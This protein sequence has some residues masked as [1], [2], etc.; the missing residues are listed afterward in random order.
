M[1]DKFTTLVPRN[2]FFHADE[3]AL[4]AVVEWM[5]RTFPD[6]DKVQATSKEKPNFF[7]AG[8]NFESVSC[9]VC[10]TELD[11]EWWSLRMSDDF[12]GD[13]FRMNKYATPCC[14]GNL[15]LNELTYDFHQAFGSCA[16]E[17]MNLNVGEFSDQQLADAARIFGTPLSVVYSHV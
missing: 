13:G 17:G 1:S 11:M 10:E 5:R 6:L 4:S 3:A 2:P 9:P 14:Q 7:D 15:T 8:A 16:V 12:D